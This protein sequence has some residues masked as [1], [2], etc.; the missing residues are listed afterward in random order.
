MIS[1]YFYSALY[2]DI[3]AIF[4]RLKINIVY[5][6]P[7]SAYN[8]DPRAAP[9]VLSS[10]QCPVTPTETMTLRMCGRRSM[11]EEVVHN[12]NA[13]RHLVFCHMYLVSV[14]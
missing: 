6:G 4:D 7:V 2:G 1:R 10:K 13:V 9:G 11:T 3:R 14:L 5:K 12:C 8:L